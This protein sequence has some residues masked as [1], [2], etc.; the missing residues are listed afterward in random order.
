M[1]LTTADAIQEME[2]REKV[3]HL[4]PDTYPEKMVGYMIALYDLGFLS[5]DMIRQYERKFGVVVFPDE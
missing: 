5:Q 1:E 3:F 2:E 4:D